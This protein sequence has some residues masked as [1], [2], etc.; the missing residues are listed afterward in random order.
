MLLCVITNHI[1]FDT[2]SADDNADIKVADFGFSRRVHTPQSL[3]TRCGTPTYVAPEIL[4][5]IPHDTQADMW[6]VGV[7][8]YVLL[9]GYPPFME[10]KQQDLFRKIRTGEF[11]FFDEDWEGISEEAIDLIKGLLVTDPKQRFTAA[12]ALKNPWFE[13]GMDLRLSSRS[14]TS[15]L[16]GLREKRHS[17]RS[18]AKVVVWMSRDPTAEPI[19]QNA[20]QSVDE[21]DHSS[22]EMM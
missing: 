1:I 11:E 20:L 21:T 8:I 22:S 13:T 18:I 17:L 19:P 9:V 15:S 2:Q 4:K 14:L 10:D 12:E 7:I 6:S 16:R 5:N 3:T